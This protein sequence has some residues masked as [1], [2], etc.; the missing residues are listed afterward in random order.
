MTF[1]FL[2]RTLVFSVL[3]IISRGVKEIESGSMNYQGCRSV[4][5]P[6]CKQISCQLGQRSLQ[7]VQLHVPGKTWG[8]GQFLRGAPSNKWTRRHGTMHGSVKPH[9]PPFFAPNQLCPWKSQHSSPG[10]VGLDRLKV[11][12]SLSA[13]KPHGLRLH[14]E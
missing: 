14:S 12:G 5:K 3:E 2:A 13:P 8:C 11:T 4:A 1:S 6:R 9:L 7:G 10:E